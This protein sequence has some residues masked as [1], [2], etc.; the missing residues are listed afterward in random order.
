MSATPNPRRGAIAQHI[1]L[2]FEAKGLGVATVVQNL[3][4]EVE[5]LKASQLRAASLYLQ[6]GAAVN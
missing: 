4:R 5:R 3:V 2:L 6:L 1:L